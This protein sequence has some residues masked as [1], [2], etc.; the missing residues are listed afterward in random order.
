VTLRSG[1]LARAALASRDHTRERRGAGG[2]DA[3]ARPAERSRRVAVISIAREKRTKAPSRNPPFAIRGRDKEFA[4]NDQTS[5]NRDI[6]SPIAYRYALPP[7]V[8]DPFVALGGAYVRS[9]PSRRS[10][11][12][13]R[14]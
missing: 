11:D 7:L 8:L 3:C 10:F 9:N 14:R 1:L 4:F 6:S 5:H 12:S 2:P 13:S